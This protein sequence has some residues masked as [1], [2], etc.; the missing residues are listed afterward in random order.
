[1][2]H[3]KGFTLIELLVVVAI[4]GI[5][6]AVTV[7]AINSARNKG[8][9]ASVKSNLRTFATQAEQV[10]YNTLNNS[11]NTTG[12]TVTSATCSTLTTAGTIFAN[13]TIQ[14]AIK[15]AKKQ[16]T[17]D[18][19]CGVS[20]GAYSVAI[21]LKDNTYWCID[22]QNVARGTTA[23]GVAYSGLTGSSGAAHT[24]SGAT[25]CN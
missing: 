18:A 5:L 12:S 8:S 21:Q 20:A 6:S 23:A 4:I 22:S 7:V 2:K 15:E 11:Y 10:Y 16:A 1:M 17:G 9:V 13:A 14:N 24:A 3:T 19:D 25:T